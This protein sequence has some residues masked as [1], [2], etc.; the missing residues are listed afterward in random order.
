MA[1][2]GGPVLEYELDIYFEI[3]SNVRKCSDK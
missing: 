3:F 2:G 1:F